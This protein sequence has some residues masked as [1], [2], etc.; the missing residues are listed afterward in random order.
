MEFKPSLAQ[1]TSVLVPNLISSS[2]TNKPRELHI[3]WVSSIAAAAVGPAS[4][5]PLPNLSAS[6]FLLLG[7]AA[8]GLPLTTTSTF[9]GDPTVSGSSLPVATS[10]LPQAASTSTGR[11]KMELFARFACRLIYP[12]I[13][14]SGQA[15]LDRFWCLRRGEGEWKLARENAEILFSTPTGAQK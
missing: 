11:L 15:G 13:Q 4:S 12:N 3:Y 2:P 5:L 1:M 14:R 6:A 9:L 8:M 7:S 10:G